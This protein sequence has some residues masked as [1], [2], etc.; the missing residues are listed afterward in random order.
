MRIL[1]TVGLG[2]WV[3]APAFKGVGGSGLE[4]ND[5]DLHLSC[6]DVDPTPNAVFWEAEDQFGL[7]LGGGQTDAFL[8]VDATKELPLVPS[9]GS[10]ALATLAGLMALLTMVWYA[11]RRTTGGQPA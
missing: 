5:F 7:F 6:Y 4:P 10:W 3:C 2:R 1:N 8:C 9:M 11:R